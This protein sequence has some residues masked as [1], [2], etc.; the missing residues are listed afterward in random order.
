MTFVKTSHSDIELRHPEGKI[1]FPGSGWIMDTHKVKSQ[2]A[3][4]RVVLITNAN[5]AR[6]Q[7]TFNVADADMG[8]AVEKFLQRTADPE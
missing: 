2:N 4:A 1:N 5:G 7:L 8:K 6:M 3:V